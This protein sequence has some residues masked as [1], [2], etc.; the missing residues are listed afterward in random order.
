MYG[1]IRNVFM[2]YYY[3]NILFTTA[4]FRRT[5]YY[6]TSCITYTSL[7]F[8]GYPRYTTCVQQYAARCAQ[9]IWIRCSHAYRG[10]F[11]IL[12][13]VHV[14]VGAYAG[15]QDCFEIATVNPAREYTFTRRYCS[16]LVSNFS[17]SRRARIWG[18][19]PIGT[20]I[21]YHVRRYDAFGWRASKRVANGSTNSPTGIHR[22]RY[23]V[24]TCARAQ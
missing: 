12:Y 3:I 8:I 24:H 17:T 13:F 14:I 22:Q 16:A 21:K 2:F 10:V 5:R 20:Y 1:V 18:I 11:P 7:Y 9:P 15:E 19:P 4:I 6:Y 23:R